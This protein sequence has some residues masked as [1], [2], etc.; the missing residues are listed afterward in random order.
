M[1]KIYFAALVL[2][3][4]H[5]TATVDTGVA[6]YSSASTTS[7]TI[8]VASATLD[9]GTGCIT[10]VNTTLDP[11]LPSWIKDNFKCL[12]GYVD[13][14][15]YTFKSANFPN[16]AS[17]YYCSSHS[18]GATTCSSGQNPTLWTALPGSNYAAGANVI[19][20]QKF[21][22]NIPATPTLKSGTLS[23]TQAGLASIGI[24]TNGLSIF[25]NAA[26]PGD[27]LSSEAVTFDGFGGHPQNTGTYH[28]H[29]SVTKVSTTMSS[30]SLLGIA[31]DGYAIYDEACNLGTGGANFTP[32]ASTT[33]ATTSTALTGNT[34]TSLDQ[35]HG[36]TT[37]TK[38]FS[39]ATYHYH[40]MQDSTATIK[41][42]MGSYF[43]GTV[44]SVS[45]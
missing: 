23:G 41:T 33:T 13:G 35:L 28:H 27:V 30:A 10:N 29:A 15:N 12:V 43:R 26:A 8:S 7:A 25:N 32:T 11:S 38:H 20:S 24:T 37:T 45:N 16:H 44:G 39:T 36:H 5:C 4:I 9:A 18:A 3:A 19:A 2:I 31:L 17:Y 14:T 1:K 21:V 34:T 40:Y 22:Y 6:S 42:L